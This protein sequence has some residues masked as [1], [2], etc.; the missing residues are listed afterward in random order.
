M[1]TDAGKS[2]ILEADDLPELPRWELESFSQRPVN[3]FRGQILVDDEVKA[4]KP[5]PE[6]V[7][8]QVETAL[9][10]KWQQVEAKHQAELKEHYETGLAKG[11]EESSAELTRSIGLLTEFSHLLQSEKAELAD[12]YEREVLDLAFQLAEKIL[13]SELKDR[14]QAVAD[15]AKQAVR[16]ILD[17]EKVQIRVNSGDL[18]HLNA[19][20]P[21]LEQML[22]A[23]AKV[24]LRADDSVTVGGCMIDTERGT[25]DARVSSQLETLKS[26]LAANR[27]SD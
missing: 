12:R 14:P 18:E 8:A 26:T 1:I 3:Y 15:I 7:E 27:K 2:R 16:Q 4:L 6:E 19:V 23:E 5:N 9:Q 21:D 17:C 11:R 20:K 10:A 22:G 25:L 24:Q 13:G